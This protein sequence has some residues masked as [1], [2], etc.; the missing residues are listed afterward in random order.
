VKVALGAAKGIAFIHIEGGSKFTHGNIKSTAILITEEF[1]SCISDVG[2]PPL[3]NAPATMS[4]TNGY[5]A[6]EVG[7]AHRL[8][9]LGY[10]TG[11]RFFGAQN[12][13]FNMYGT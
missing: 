11:P 10:G 4:R 8:S 7:P 12:I 13:F 3:M 2:L 5:R 1:D 9:R 6:P